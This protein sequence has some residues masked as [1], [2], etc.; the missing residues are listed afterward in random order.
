MIIEDKRTV[1]DWMSTK[2]I[3]VDAGDRITKAH[4]L[5]DTNNIHHLIVLEKGKL[6]G[7]LSKE[8]L[9]KAYGEEG[10]NHTMVS[11]IMTANPMTIEQDDNLGLA[12]D[13]ILANR[14]HALPVVD[15]VEL[16]GII[17]SHDLIRCFYDL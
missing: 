4:Q 16:V 13:I 3:S 14:F 15:G 9:L 5:F 11:E 2:I 1:S 12:A 8:D 10:L 6:V 17:T 7:I